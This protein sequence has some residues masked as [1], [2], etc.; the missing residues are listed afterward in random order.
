M[1]RIPKNDDMNGM[2]RLA[3]SKNPKYGDEKEYR[4]I[5]FVD[6]DEPG[7]FRL[8]L[9]SIRD[10]ADA[11]ETRNIYETITINGSKDF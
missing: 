4:F 2:I 3:F 5:F 6:R 10:I 11:I 1:D 9:G 7:P 8:D